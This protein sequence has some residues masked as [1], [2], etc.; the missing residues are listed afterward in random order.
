MNQ[1]QDRLLKG[2]R[3]LLPVDVRKKD[4][5]INTI[6][7]V[8][9]SYGFEPIETPALEYASTL[10]GKSGSETEKL[11]YKFKD[12]GEREIGLRYDLTVP[13]A[14]F[15]RTYPDLS[16]PFKR[17]QIQPVWRAEKPQAGRFREFLQCDF[18]IVGVNSFLA[19]TEI[20]KI[21]IECLESL[22]LKNFKI[23]LNDRQI[24][25]ETIKK[26]GVKEKEISSVIRTLDKLEKIGPKAVEKELIKKGFGPKAKSI[27]QAIKE[28]KPNQN[29]S[30]IINNLKQNGF[31]DKVEF[32]STL[33]RGLDYYTSIIFEIIDK[34][35][36]SGSIGGGGRYDNL[37]KNYQGKELPAVGLSFGIDRLIEALEKQGEKISSNDQTQVL[38]T[39]F[40]E[41]YTEQSNLIASKLREKKIN[42]ELYLEDDKLNKQLKYADKKGIPYVIII[43]PD[44]DKN[45]TLTI[46][47]LSS[48]RQTSIAADK[49]DQLLS[50]LNH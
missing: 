9:V 14:R 47:E 5:V 25:F 2:F 29:I 17:Y 43:G 13:L 31:E 10:L 37:A 39:V 45:K 12:R 48:G 8:F 11:I 44:E 22:G 3:D 32:Y 27:L 4:F 34:K 19:D 42:T 18:D 15:M 20:I 50:F 35:Y 1:G 30:K 6:K 24:L 26:A 36:Q 49:I 33:A 38:V 16:L 40:E 28:A 46:K 23:I 41:N 21:T 7:K